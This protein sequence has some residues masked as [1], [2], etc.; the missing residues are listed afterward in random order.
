[1]DF[2]LLPASSV[3]ASIVGPVVIGLIVLWVFVETFGWNFTGIVVPGYLACV[4]VLQPVTAAFM[5]VEILL[6]WL[7]VVSVSDRITPNWPWTPFFGRERFLL[8]LVVSVGVRVAVEGGLLPLF[9]T[10][11]GSLSTSLHSMGFVVV[12]LAANALWRTGLSAGITRVGVPVLVVWA[13]LR[14]IVLPYTSISLQGFQLAYEDLALSFLSSPRAYILLL[15]GAWVGSVASRRYGWDVGGISVSGLLALSWLQPWRIVSTLAEA[16]IIIVTYRAFVRLPGI[17]NLNL[18]GGRPFLIAAGLAFVAKA[19]FARALAWWLPDL[20]AQQFFA[21][22]YLLSALIALRCVRYGEIWRPIFGAVVTSFT[23]FGLGSLVGYGLAVLLPAPAPEPLKETASST[24]SWAIELWKGT[25]R[26]VREEPALA[27]TLLSGRRGAVYSVGG[28]RGA[29]FWNREGGHEFAVAVVNDAPLSP[30]VA[31]G[32]AEKLNARAALVCAAAGPECERAIRDLSGELP[33]VRVERV[34]AGEEPSI[35]APGQLPPDLDVGVLRALEEQLHIL[36]GEGEGTR[37]RLSADGWNAAANLGLDADPVR[38]V[39]TISDPPAWLTVS[40][41]EESTL[42]AMQGA[43]FGPLEA[44]QAN[45]DEQ[46]LRIAAAAARAFGLT[47]RRDGALAVLDGPDWRVIVRTSSPGDARDGN[48]LVMCPGSSDEPTTLPAAFA[49]GEALGAS[50]YVLDSTPTLTSEHLPRVRPSHVALL[51]FLLTPSMAARPTVQVI[52]VRDVNDQLDIGA[53]IVTSIGRPLADNPL[54][55]DS[56]PLAMPLIEGLSARSG[57]TTARYD[58][59]GLRITLQDPFDPV[60]Y[61]ARASQGSDAHVAV[62]VGP[63][64]RARFRRPELDVKLS[65][66]L[67]NLSQRGLAG[68]TTSTL[69]E[70]DASWDGV[71]AAM[72]DLAE[73]TIRSRFD[74]V[75][76]QATIAGAQTGLVCD[77][78]LG[79]RWLVFERTDGDTR[80]GLL[81]PLVRGGS[82]EAGDFRRRISLGSGDVAWTHLLTSPAA[83]TPSTGVAP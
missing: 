56:I 70:P 3:D 76:N 65:P 82:A 29:G 40:D 51:R 26:D 42:L 49:L 27:N 1:M 18:A 75:I 23:G 67:V 10:R 8:V 71:R 36:V 64:A 11:A 53:D 46:Q 77:P 34:G 45:G 78:L 68:Y 31:A 61:A 63:G 14:F 7:V 48:L 74:A 80:R 6:A 9:A 35:E 52:S 59:D 81:A 60:R 22:G 47:V 43:L 12:P 83:E 20:G 13:V 57:L 16:V 54:Y 21:F 73:L 55:A 2:L 62:F 33:I 17:R 58:G 41:F 5:G 66:L 37:V 39:G 32:L 69:D 15:F 44:W 19:L 79:C 24:T 50:L 4:L 25:V 72:D 28:E 30:A 38:L